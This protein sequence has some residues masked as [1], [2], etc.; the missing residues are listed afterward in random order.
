VKTAHGYGST[1]SPEP[2]QRGGHDGGAPSPQPPHR[3]RLPVNI[4]HW[5]NISLLHWPF[6]ADDITRMVPKQLKVLTYDGMAWLTITPFFIQ[7]RLPGLPWVP[8]PCAFPETNLRTYVAAPDG[9]QGLWFLRMEVTALWFVAAL[10]T[11][12]LP[13]FRQ[14][15]SVDINDERAVYRSRPQRLSSGGGHH[16]VVCP[17]EELRP[18]QGGP[19]D[20]FV[21]ARWGAFHRRGPLLLYTPV[22]HGPWHL[23]AAEVPVCSVDALFRDAGLPAPAGPPVAHFSAGVRVKVGVPKLVSRVR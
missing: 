3:V 9:R 16:I 11:V 7:V 6:A 19:W 5:D 12:G 17:G 4:H 22:E 20:R 21:T 15:M 23:R 8:P 1:V 2:D 13:Y 18:V 10:R 14:R